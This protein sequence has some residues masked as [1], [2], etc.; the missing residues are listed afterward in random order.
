MQFGAVWAADCSYLLDDW[1]KKVGREVTADDVEILTWALAEHGPDRSP[2]RSSSA[3]S[4][5]R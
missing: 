5:T 2:P 1:G 4:P 3:R